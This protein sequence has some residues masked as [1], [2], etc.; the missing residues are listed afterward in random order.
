MSFATCCCGVFTLRQGTG[1]LASYL[2][3]C[4]LAELLGMHVLPGLLQMGC[5]ALGVYAAWENKV[6][7][8]RLYNYA[9]L[10]CCVL[11]ILLSFKSV[12]STRTS[13]CAPAIARAI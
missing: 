5:G 12:G 3:L 4:G 13:D 10:A 9:L 7:P 8:A 6:E 2:A 1:L 11:R